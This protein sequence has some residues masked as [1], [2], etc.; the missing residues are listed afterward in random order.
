MTE[1]ETRRL[2][3]K[4]EQLLRKQ[5][6]RA[7]KLPLG[8]QLN[9]LLKLEPNRPCPCLSGV[10]FK[11][12]CRPKLPPVLTDAI[13]NEWKRQMSHPDLVFLTEDNRERIKEKAAPHICEALEKQ[14]TKQ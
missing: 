9:P 11:R 3:R 5:A 4:G 2:Q 6:D 14:E 7:W 13:A 12:C 10:K 1:L 8:F